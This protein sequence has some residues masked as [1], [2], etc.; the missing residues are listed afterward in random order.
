VMIGLERG[1]RGTQQR[2]SIF[3]LGAHDGD[4]APVYLGVSSCL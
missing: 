4:V 1:R 2:H 3:E